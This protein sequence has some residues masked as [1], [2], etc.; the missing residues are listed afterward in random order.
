MSIIIT[1]RTPTGSGIFTEKTFNCWDE[2]MNFAHT[3]E[4]SSEHVVVTFVTHE[5]FRHSIPLIEFTQ[6]K[7]YTK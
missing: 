5:N 7:D 4:W 3:N 1:V 2:A 6:P